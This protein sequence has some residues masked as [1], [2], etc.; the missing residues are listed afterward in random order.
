MTPARRQR[1]CHYPHAR[2][3]NKIQS[4][5][6]GAIVFAPENLRPSTDS[7]I[8]FNP[9]RA[10]HPPGDEQHSL[11]KKDPAKQSQQGDAERLPL[12]VHQLP[13]LSLLP[14]MAQPTAEPEHVYRVY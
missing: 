8:R 9:L 11:A 12:L 2:N 7:S 4:N 3:I 6:A 13:S 5:L 14:I 10:F 1:K